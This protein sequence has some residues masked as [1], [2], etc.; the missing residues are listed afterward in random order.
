LAPLK[1]STCLAKGGVTLAPL[2][3]MLTGRIW[4]LLFDVLHVFPRMVT[5][6]IYDVLESVTLKYEDGRIDKPDFFKV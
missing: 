4:P 1:S 2:L 6:D 3:L 5:R